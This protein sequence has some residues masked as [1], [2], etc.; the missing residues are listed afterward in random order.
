MARV[1]ADNNFGSSGL[2]AR[3]MGLNNNWGARVCPEFQN[4]LINITSLVDSFSVNQF[5]YFEKKIV[6]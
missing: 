6:R 5:E 4:L 2:Y 1:I 3:Q